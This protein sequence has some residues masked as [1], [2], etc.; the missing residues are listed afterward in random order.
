MFSKIPHPSHHWLFLAEICST[1]PRGS[2]GSLKG[3]TSAAWR[4]YSYRYVA[5]KTFPILSFA[6]ET[7]RLEK[8]YFDR[9]SVTEKNNSSVELLSKTNFDESQA[10]PNGWTISCQSS[11]SPIASQIISDAEC[12]EQQR[13]CL[14]IQCKANHSSIIVL[15]QAF[16]AELEKTYTIQFLLSQEPGD[17]SFSVDI[18]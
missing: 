14:R 11:C 2:I 3:S 8:F 13:S 6:F 17:S 7:T 5:T 16:V 4:S 18:E 1:K 15:Q 9:V 10:D 12:S